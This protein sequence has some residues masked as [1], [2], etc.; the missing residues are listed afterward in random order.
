MGVAARLVAGI[1]LLLGLAPT[2]AAQP[3]VPSPTSFVEFDGTSAYLEVP[4]SPDFSVATTGALTISAWLRPDALTM[5]ST[6]GSGYVYWLGKGTRGQYE[7][8]L[9][10]YSQDNTEN[11][12]R[13]NRISFYVFNPRGGLG[14]GSYFQD[15]I[16]PGEW[17]HVVA[18]ADN[19]KTSI[20]KNGV[21]RRCD[22]Y[23]APADNSCQH[24][25]QDLWITPQPGPQPVRMGTRDFN[26]YFQGGLA[27]V[28]IWNRPLG[29]DEVTQLYA[30]DSTPRDG[31]VAEYL[32]AEGSGDTAYDTAGGH[33][34]SLQGATWGS[35]CSAEPVVNSQSLCG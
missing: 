21:F 26:S 28:R 4:D 27:E 6:E 29:A 33:D 13:A 3:G 19:G 32:F 17:I 34:A 18:I 31:L 24:Y 8:A 22:W 9:R 16:T 15:P 30:Q 5:A 20:Y 11:P 23:T 35:E 7:W 1:V 14:I 2:A 10:M 12:N 25:A